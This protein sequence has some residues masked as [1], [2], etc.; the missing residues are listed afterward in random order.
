MVRRRQ[1]PLFICFDDR[2]GNAGDGHQGP[3]RRE[4]HVPKTGE[5]QGKGDALTGAV[6]RD[7]AIHRNLQDDG[8][9]ASAARPAPREIVL[10][11]M[12]L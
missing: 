5:R 2:A 11:W 8:P 10:L 12:I 6:R 3:E 9:V 1:P 4:S 7:R